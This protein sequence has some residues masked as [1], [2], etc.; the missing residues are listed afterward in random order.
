[1]E[2]LDKANGGRRQ[3]ESQ[4]V[5]EEGTGSETS[6]PR[7]DVWY[8]RHQCF[9]HRGL[10]Q[11]WV[12]IL[13]RITCSGQP[14]CW[15][16]LNDGDVLPFRLGPDSRRLN[17]PGDF[18]IDLP[19][20]ELIEGTNRLVIGVSTSDDSET[21]QEVRESVEIQFVRT[22]CDRE[23]LVDWRDC[24]SIQEQAQIVDGLWRLENGEVRTCETGYD[25]IIAVGDWFWQDYE[26]TVPLTIHDVDTSVHGVLPSYHSAV[27][28]VMRFQGHY[29]WDKSRPAWGYAPV[30]MIVWYSFIPDLDDFRL[31]FMSGADRDVRF[32]KYDQ[33]GKKLQHGIRYL[34]KARVQSR[35]SSVSVYSMKAWAEGEAEP[36]EWDVH[37]E[38]ILAEQ[39]RGAVNLIAHHVDASFGN[40]RVSTLE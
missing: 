19:V 3:E 30:G 36:D 34:L 16:S 24:Q 33:T 13:G 39:C 31:C 25:R 4:A 7:I 11:R 26:V 35:P 37:A 28:L 17:N 18:N 8:G 21:R 22:S 10:P 6:M 5:S 27:G 32:A 38:G 14:R 15:Y 1:M 20:D 23:L 12:N 29:D 2:P 40:V 9:G